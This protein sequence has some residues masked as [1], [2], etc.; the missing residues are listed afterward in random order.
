LTTDDPARHWEHLARSPVTWLV[1][2]ED[3]K[4]CAELVGERFVSSFTRRLPPGA[5]EHTEGVQPIS[6]GPILQMLAGYSIEALVKGICIAREPNAVVGGKLPGWLTTHDVEGLLRRAH[7]QL[8]DV[9]QSFVRRLH[10]SV[11]W[12]GRYPIP[13]KAGAVLKRYSSGDLVAFR[14][15][16]EKLVPVLQKE[17][18]R[19]SEQKGDS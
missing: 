10:T 15:L 13:K 11:L 5:V 12:S 7:V 16:Y 19:A 17:L 6:F 14:R 9:E 18:L 3:L 4:A 8:T 2:A 1:S